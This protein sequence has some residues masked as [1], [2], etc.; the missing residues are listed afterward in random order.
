M[1]KDKDTITHKTINAYMARI[2]AIQKNFKRWVIEEKD[3][4][5]YNGKRTIAEIRLDKDGNVTSKPSDYKP[6]EE[7]AA[8]IKAEVK[9]KAFPKTITARSETLP[10]DLKCVPV[11]HLCVFADKSGKGTLMVQHRRDGEKPDWPWTC[12]SDGVWRCMEPDGL[13]PIYGQNYFKNAARV[14]LHEGAKAA[15]DVQLMVD[16]Y[17]KHP[18]VRTD[19]EKASLAACPWIRDLAAPGGVAWWC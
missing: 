7:E 8:A 15:R 16:A 3:E 19:K 6:T 13:L 1:K 5:S 14:Y 17:K 12:W 2:G 11:E 18:S 10:D 4:E 9:L